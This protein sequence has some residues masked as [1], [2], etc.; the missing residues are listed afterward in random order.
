L[1]D[2]ERDR[3]C[4]N[5][6]VPATDQSW[7]PDKKRLETS[8]SRLRKLVERPVPRLARVPELLRVA[9][10]LCPS[11]TGLDGIRAVV[12]LAIH[13]L[14]RDDWTDIAALLYGLTEQ[15]RGKP[16][17]TRRELAYHLYLERA[18]IDAEHFSVETFRTG[19]EPWIIKDLTAALIA[20]VAAYYEKP[21]A[22]ID[23]TSTDSSTQAPSAT[24][25]PDAASEPAVLAQAPNLPATEPIPARP[26]LRPRRHWLPV[27]ALCSIV[28]AAALIAAL[29][30]GD[31]TPRP[32]GPTTARLV[33]LS[34]VPSAVE[35]RSHLYI[36]APHQFAA[37]HGWASYSLGYKVPSKEVFRFGEV[38]QLV[39][40]FHNE[41]N[42]PKE[43][44]IARVGLAQGITLQPGSTCVY[45]GAVSAG[46]YSAGASLVQ[47]TGLRLG[48]IDPRANVYVTFAVKLPESS[49]ETSETIYGGIG[50]AGDLPEPNW[51]GNQ[52]VA[53]SLLLS[54]T[55]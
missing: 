42:T 54:L 19:R 52:E 21:T 14:P 1:S 5:P 32:C 35:S 27:A 6:A 18:G 24:A 47:P 25:L 41:A 23:A 33:S 2:D 31:N 40:G 13:H 8:L 53:S 49:S 43:N 50:A 17:K 20:L 39:L 44:V 37:E 51:Y 10:L 26:P 11:L 3:D 46:A 16:L 45:R 12:Q 36:Y 15:S 38:R 34:P 28:G 48:T 29:A 22:M 4:D 30:T 9:E 55:Q 7:T